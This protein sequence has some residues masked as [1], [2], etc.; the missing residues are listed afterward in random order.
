MLDERTASWKL[1]VPGHHGERVLVVGLEAGGVAGLARS[2]REVVWV[3]PSPEAARSFE[4]LGSNADGADCDELLAR[5][6]ISP[7]VNGD[8]A[9]YDTVVVASWP[10]SEQPNV[11]HLA[12][13]LAPD[14]ALV[15]LGFAGSRLK[16][17]ELKRLGFDQV[18][19]YAALPAHQPRLYFSTASRA[20]RSKSLSFHVPGSRRA[21]RTV[22]ASRHL[23]TLG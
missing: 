2:W 20:M 10:R 12:S 11:A 5:V 3:P 15:S 9:E 19:C 6:R 21:Q 7:S 13:L 22:W 4:S 18:R 23:S 14:G 17:T 8:E 16:P 1:L